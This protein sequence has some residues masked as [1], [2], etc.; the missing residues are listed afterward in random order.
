MKVLMIFIVLVISVSCQKKISV[1]PYQLSMPEEPIIVVQIKDW[2]RD[3]H[4]CLVQYEK[5]KSKQELLHDIIT[6]VEY[7]EAL[8]DGY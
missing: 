6:V 7:V 8:Q 2:V 3:C 5:S 1:A 4:E